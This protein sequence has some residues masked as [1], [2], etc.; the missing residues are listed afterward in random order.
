MP[1]SCRAFHFTCATICLTFLALTVYVPVFA[2][3]LT[4]AYNWKPVKIGAGGFMRGMAVDASTKAVK[5]ARGDVDNLY[6]WD[7]LSKTWSPTKVEGAFPSNVTAAPTQA[8]CGAIAIDPLNPKVVLAAFTFSR[9]ADISAVYP[10][11]GLNIYRSIDGGRHFSAGN[12]SLKGSLENETNGERIAIDPS[13]DNV[14]YFGS[15]NDGLFRSIDGGVTWNHVDLNIVTS[16]GAKLSEPSLPRIDGAVGKVGAFGLNVSRRIFIITEGGQVVM[17]DDGGMAWTDISVN[18]SLDSHAAFASVDSSGALWVCQN[19]EGKIWRFS[20]GGAWVSSSTPHDVNGVAVDP[21]NPMRAFVI[22]GG[23][24]LARTTDGGT[25]WTDLGA[26]LVFSETQQIEWLRPSP[27]RPQNHYISEGGI[28]IDGSG[29]LWIPGANDGILSA[30]PDDTVDS[31]KN[32]PIWSSVSQGIEEMVAQSA[33]LPP[34]G[35]PVL[36]VE[37]ETLFTISDP[38][39]FTAKHFPL[40]LWDNNNGLANAQDISYCPNNSK[41]LALTADNAYANNPQVMSSNFGSYSTDG[42]DTWKRFP[43]IVNGSHPPVLYLGSIAVSA[44]NPNE[45]NLAEHANIVWIPTNKYSPNSLAPFYTKDGGKTWVQ[46]HSFDKAPGAS[47]VNTGGVDYQYLGMQW[48]PWSGYI[49]QHNLAA[50]PIKPGTFYVHLCA[51]GFWRSGDGGVTW[52]QTSGSSQVA[53][54]AHHGH[55]AANPYTSGDL[56]FIDGYEGATEH[57]LWHT[58]D[59]GDSFTKVAGFDHCWALA[60]GKAA[61]PGGYPA[62]YVYGKRSEISHWGVFRS[63]DEGKTWDQISGYPTGLIDVP[64]GMAASWDTFGLVYLGFRG[65]SY[66]YGK[67]KAAN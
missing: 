25:S 57:G 29:T 17:S 1:Q 50:D 62:I 43:S 44:Q 19:N 15:P 20:K 34:G 31:A 10:S 8:G 66:V 3:D 16:G 22:G 58:T 37:D 24:S 49:M 67:P 12:L 56:W 53:G 7:G 40:N 35:K 33:A 65:N 59:G 60:L 30:K 47:V 5:Y 54:Y 2:A 11:V 55:L 6:R 39:A 48:G 23:G 14:A 52:T 38:D 36:T 18:T 46:T 45:T 13:N 28:Y 4:N 32:P 64:A 51:G 26:N 9:S 27:I 41:Y 21:H 42:G 61:K 63:T